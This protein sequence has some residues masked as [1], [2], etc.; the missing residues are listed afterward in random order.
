MN[1]ALRF[2]ASRR[3]DL[4]ARDHGKVVG[5][6]GCRGESVVA[7]EVA[8]RIICPGIANSNWVRH[9]VGPDLDFV[10][11]LN[12]AFGPVPH[13]ILAAHGE[14]DHLVDVK[15]TEGAAEAIEG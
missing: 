5:A 8:H 12:G 1:P 14:A 10:F 7:E 15:R 2:L 4:R 13:L 9:L 11:S 6:E 3:R